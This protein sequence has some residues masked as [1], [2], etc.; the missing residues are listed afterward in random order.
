M[1]TIQLLFLTAILCLISQAGFAGGCPLSGGGGSGGG[2]L[3]KNDPL[4]KLG[5]GIIFSD[6]LIL[7]KINITEKQA[8]SLKVLMDKYA[9]KIMAS[10]KKGIKSGADCSISTF[11]KKNSAKNELTKFCNAAKLN[12]MF[13]SK[14]TKYAGTVLNKK[15]TYVLLKSVQALKGYANYSDNL[16]KQN[17]KTNY[18]MKKMQVKVQKFLNKLFAKLNKTGAASI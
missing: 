12:H 3:S 17:K 4:Y 2:S 1:K 14:I 10:N 15:Q 18:N 5:K 16:V 9:G 7:S 8:K 6:G 11:N 13:L